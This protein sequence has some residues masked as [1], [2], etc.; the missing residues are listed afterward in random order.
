[1]VQLLN[2]MLGLKYSSI[3]VPELFPPCNNVQIVLNPSAFAAYLISIL[4]SPLYRLQ[5]RVGIA[6]MDDNKL[7]LLDV[8]YH[9]DGSGVQQQWL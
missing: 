9:N 6:Y 7:H 3:S 8:W 4:F 5:Q 1:M 2:Y